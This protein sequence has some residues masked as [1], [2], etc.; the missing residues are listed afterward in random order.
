MDSVE[1][2][3]GIV[4]LLI[5]SGKRHIYSKVWIHFHR[6]VKFRGKR[7]VFDNFSRSGLGL[8]SLVVQQYS[9]FYDI[10]YL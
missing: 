2:L 10:L 9:L 4:V 8:F 5:V 7:F 3:S 1:A 6:R